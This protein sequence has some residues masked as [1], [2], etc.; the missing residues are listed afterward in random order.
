[1][2]FRWVNL[3]ITLSLINPNLLTSIN[4]FDTRKQTGLDGTLINMHGID[5]WTSYELSWLD[6][7]SI[8]KNEILYLTYDSS[9]KKFIESK[10]LKLYLN[11]LNNCKF[12]NK[13]RLTK[14]LYKKILVVVFRTMSRLKYY[15]PLN[16]N[17]IQACA[18]MT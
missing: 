11:S 16:Q 10:S 8:P 6:S 2:K 18:L 3:L 15:L 14:K 12:K 4:R 7:K 13:G 5:A 17:K 9:S 1:M